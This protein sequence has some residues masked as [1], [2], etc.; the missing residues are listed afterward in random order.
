MLS[1]NSI[2]LPEMTSESSPLLDQSRPRD[3]YDRTFERTRT[4]SE[5]TGNSLEVNR[6]FE[7]MLNRS[8]GGHESLQ[9]ILAKYES[10][11]YDI[12]ENTLYLKEIK[13]YTGEEII[14][15]NINRWVVMFIIAVITALIACAI[16]IC[17]SLLSGWKYK[18]IKNYIEKCT[19]EHCIAAPYALWVA[20]DVMFVFIAAMLVTYLEPVAAGS[21]IPQIKC[22]LNGVKVPHVVRFKTLLT[23]V[24]GV[25][26]SVSGGLACGKE[27]PMIHSG[28]VIAAGVSQGRSTTFNKDLKIFEYFR[29]DHEKRDFVSGGAAAGVA[30]AFGA[31]IGGVLFSLEEGASFWNQSL[32]WRMFFAS[33]V[34]TFTLNLVLSIYK[35]QPGDLSN[36]GLIN[37]GSFEGSPYYGYEL[38][39]F[40][41]MGV[42][43]GLLGALFN[44][45]NHHLSLFRMQYVKKNWMR[46]LEACIVATLTV[47]TAFVL[48]YFHNDCRPLGTANITDPL[49]FFC[50]DGEYSAMGTLVFSTPEESIKN[51]FHL[52]PESYTPISLL[53]FFPI[54]FLLA[55]WTYGLYVPSGLFV[56]CILTGASWGRLFGVL[57]HK[58]FPKG[59]WV[60]PGRYALIGAAATLGG[61]VRMTLSLTVI[62]MEATGNITYGMPMMLVLMTAKFVGDFFN[63]G[64]YDIHIKLQG[65]PFLGWEPPVMASE[66]FAKDIMS[67]PV[68]CFKTK[69]K[70]GRI[71]DV[72]KDGMSHHNGFPV[73]EQQEDHSSSDTGQPTFG[74]FRGFSPIVLH[75]LLLFHS[76]GNDRKPAIQSLMWCY[77][78]YILQ[79]HSFL[80]SVP[81]LFSDSDRPLRRH[82][83]QLKDFRDAYPR[84]PPIRNIN[85]SQRE[86][87]CYIDLTPFMNPAPYTVQ[88]S[89]SLPRVFR[90]FRALGLRHIV[91][92]DDHNRVTGIATRKDLAR[93]RM[94]S[95]RGQT[96]LEVVHVLQ[97]SDLHT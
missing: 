39:I 41:I 87:E 73:V 31:P 47:S 61:V 20:I 23:K 89:S 38:P 11:D 82:G 49:Q 26:F 34:S 85:I 1:N 16:D 36:P 66:V 37:F 69:E 17:I 54:Y 81:Q 59:T 76:L 95:H 65:V 5:S 42:I 57:L 62:L 48:I 28:A 74:V 4:E 86:R 44:A 60:D 22:Y 43:G 30:A 40:M 80:S 71:V 18:N 46:V 64:I 94:W 97:S 9:K 56:P 70:V 29:T 14:R 63:E 88:E 77:T 12:P 21:G 90:L 58:A 75:C 72:L 78:Q 6:D 25:I 3:Y 52:Q 10:L 91:V 67:T 96:G 33:M 24:V 8:S 27:G 7:G 55:T 19:S 83:L 35:G 50:N 53:S 68:I 45:I 15:T 84:F 93:Y 92:V 2:N 13:S 51:L 79:L 32:T